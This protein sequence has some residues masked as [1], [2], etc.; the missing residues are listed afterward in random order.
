MKTID[1]SDISLSNKEIKTRLN[2][3]MVK[4]NPL[5]EEKDYLQK[6]YQEALKDPLNVQW[7]ADDLKQDMNNKNIHSKRSKGLNVEQYQND[8]SHLFNEKLYKINP[9]QLTDLKNK[10]EIND[11]K[12]QII[13]V[14][15]SLMKKRKH[16]NE[17]IHPK[18][19]ENNLQLI[20]PKNNDNKFNI[21]PIETKDKQI[22]IYQMINNNNLQNEP[23]PMNYLMDLHNNVGMNNNKINQQNIHNDL[24]LLPNNTNQNVSKNNIKHVIN[25]INITNINSKRQSLLDNKYQH[26]SKSRRTIS[27]PRELTERSALFDSTNDNYL[28]NNNQNIIRRNS[29]NNLKYIPPITYYNRKSPSPP[30]QEIV[31]SP[32]NINIIKPNNTSF[33]N[34]FDFLIKAVP[35]V[36]CGVCVYFCIKH[37]SVIQNKIKSF[38][39][40]ESEE[41]DFNSFPQL[42]KNKFSSLSASILNS[43]IRVINCLLLSPIKSFYT[44]VFINNFKYVIIV[45]VIGIIIWF[46]YSKYKEYKLINEIFSKIKKELEE[47]TEIQEDNESE[48]SNSFEHGM[49]EKEIIKKYSQMYNIEENKFKRKYFPKLKKM[50]KSDLNLKEYEVLL[51]G[52]RQIIWQYSL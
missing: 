14:K 43:L 21:P 28:N 18:T 38:F 39:P 23:T 33:N 49:T 36:G 48:Y 22:N 52:K 27:N 1:T 35:F 25:N 6:K 4:Y 40:S 34:S 16:K 20:T 44:D 8:K 29:S 32:T 3:M 47:L 11:N 42:L 7:I 30:R 10:D 45:C 2:K 17:I 37:H 13:K 24:G 26:P 50:R 31:L 12:D 41:F 5:I 9:Q 15:F 19:I 46:A 51:Q